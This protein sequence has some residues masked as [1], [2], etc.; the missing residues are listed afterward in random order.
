MPPPSHNSHHQP[1]PLQH[2]PPATKL[3]QTPSGIKMATSMS[4]SM[5]GFE[6]D[7]S[8]T[9]P[10][11]MEINEFTTV[12]DFINMIQDESRTYVPEPGV[13]IPPVMSTHAQSLCVQAASSGRKDLLQAAY[14]SGLVK[15][16]K[17]VFTGAAGGG[18]LETMKCLKFIGCPWDESTAVAAVESGDLDVLQWVIEN[19]CP[20]NGKAMVT[21]ASIGHLGMVRFL[22]YNGHP[23]TVDAIEEAVVS[24]AIYIVEWARGVG[25]E[26]PS[27]FAQ[28]IMV[29]DTGVLDELRKIGYLWDMT[30]VEECIGNFEVDQE[31]VEWLRSYGYIN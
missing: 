21:A 11:D 28:A 7:F 31:V 27:V 10:G 15:K 26:S 25:I 20:C 13:Y 16:S 29:G 9:S 4:T 24:G 22:Y 12:K 2:Q 18:C 19:G 5:G 6:Y 17:E 8:R 1:P 30:F 14:G 3:S 23:V